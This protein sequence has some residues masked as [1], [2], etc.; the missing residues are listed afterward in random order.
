MASPRN[1]GHVSVTG[2]VRRKQDALPHA[3]SQTGQLGEPNTKTRRRQQLARN[4]GRK[5]RTE[6]HPCFGIPPSTEL[7][8][9]YFMAAA[10][11][12]H[13]RTNTHEKALLFCLYHSLP[14][15]SCSRAGWRAA[16]EIGTKQSGTGGPTRLVRQIRRPARKTRPGQKEHVQCTP[17][18]E[19]EESVT[20]ADPPLSMCRTGVVC[21]E[22]GS[23]GEANLRFGGETCGEA[24]FRV[25]ALKKGKMTSEMFVFYF[26]FFLLRCWR[27]LTRASYVT[28]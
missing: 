11:L 28:L 19:K 5:E 8:A 6:P 7:P 1:R 14:L 9:P 3:P 21:G 26:F 10:L 2:V 15:L 4:T 12:T 13:A 24:R 27:L 25:L 17:P 22:R 20:S 18:N 23:R 16:A